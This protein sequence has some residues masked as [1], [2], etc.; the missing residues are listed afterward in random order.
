MNSSVWIVDVD[1]LPDPPIRKVHRQ[2]WKAEREYRRQK[3][4]W[5]DR[6]VRVFL[7]VVFDGEHN[8]KLIR[9]HVPSGRTMSDGDRLTIPPVGLEPSDS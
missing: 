9:Q 7:D 5:H 3:R 6:W 4:Y 8:M 1:Q 2:K